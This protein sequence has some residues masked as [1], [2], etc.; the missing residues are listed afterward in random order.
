MI[1]SVFFISLGITFILIL[2]LVYHFKQRVNSIEQKCDTMFELM[3]NVV[4]EMNTQRN[5]AATSMHQLMGVNP[6]GNIAFSIHANEGIVENEEGDEENE[7]GDE[8]NEESDE[9][10]DEESEEENEESDEDE[11]GDDEDEDEEDDEESEEEKDEDEAKESPNEIKT[12]NVDLDSESSIGANLPVECE[13]ETTEDDPLAGED[14]NLIGFQPSD[15][16]VEK[17]P[18]EIPQD[19]L[20]EPQSVP[21]TNT[22]AH[23]DIYKKMTLPA[24]KALSIE[25]GL[26]SDPSKLKKPELIAL[27]ISN[28]RD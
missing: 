17:L 3:N 21:P 9:D 2:L 10:E 12:V 27:F 8:E 13:L 25:R 4:S 19:H 20:D 23:H 18:E 28:D 15:L 6:S 5:Y 22:P 24:L 26:V 11:E 14:L 16:H 7:E 1:E